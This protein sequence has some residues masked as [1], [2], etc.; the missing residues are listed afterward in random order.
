MTSPMISQET[1]SQI[2]TL[3]TSDAPLILCDVDEVVLQFVSALEEY[4]LSEGYWLDA[5]SFALTGNVKHKADNI[6]ADQ[7]EVATLV[8]GFFER[9]TAHLD[10]V[11]GATESLLQLG[12]I[13]D[14]IMLTNMPGA[15]R[16]ERIDN[17]RGHGLHF[18]VITNSGPK[19]PVAAH[20][21]S[22]RKKPVFFIDDMPGNVRSV[23]EAVPDAYL[24]HFIADLRFAALADDVGA[25]HLR[26]SC[27]TETSR[28]IGETLVENQKSFLP[29]SQ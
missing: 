1:A 13:A 6:P 14:V 28:F 25:A 11:P 24:I 3:K 8:N 27:W 10:V 29:S 26:T 18:P 23:G 15:F 16:H 19:G 17:L 22:R 9:R 21:A 20:L 2:A 4:L 12:E 7:T 5:Q